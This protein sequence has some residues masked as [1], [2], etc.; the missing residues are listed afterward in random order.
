M[1]SIENGSV[2]RDKCRLCPISTR[3][4]LRGND[5]DGIAGIG[6][7]EQYLTVVVSEVC[8]LNNLRDKRPK[9]ESLV[10][11]LVVKDQAKTFDFAGLFNKEKPTNKL[12]RY[13]E[14][15]LPH[16]RRADLFEDPFQHISDLHHIR[17]ISLVRVIS[18]WS[19]NA[20]YVGISFH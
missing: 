14:R 1:K 2:C 8:I 17:E 6:F 5:G 10:C 9:F 4:I 19:Q 13:G 20:V 3:K 18:Q 16:F 11:G 15:R 7:N 12:F